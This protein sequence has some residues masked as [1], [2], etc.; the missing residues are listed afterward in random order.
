MSKG[1]RMKRTL[2]GLVVAAIALVAVAERPANAQDLQQR[3]AAVKQSVTANQQALRS[4][5]W[6]EKTEL[7]LK[8][9]VKATKVDSCRYGPD[10][11][12]QKTPVVQPPPPEKK[13]GLRGK[14]VANKTAEMKEELQ[15]TV[16][17]IQQYVPPDPGL[18]QVVMNAGTA[19]LGQAGPELVAFNFPGYA[20]QGDALTITFDKAITALR[21][22]DVETWLEKPEEPATLRVVMQSMPNGISFPGSIVLNIPASKIEV[23]ITKSNYQKLAM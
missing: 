9:E 2:I 21:Q 10:G 3:L 17:L 1:D 23:R 8:G 16:A 7:S 12:V 13:R 15:A 19:S 11:K 14:I 22:I 5:T 20:K 18:I 4:Y 6:L